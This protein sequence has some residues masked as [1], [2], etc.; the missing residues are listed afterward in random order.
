MQEKTC[1]GNV[2]HVEFGAI[3]PLVGAI[4]EGELVKGLRTHQ[5]S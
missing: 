2:V 5:A 4:V 3:L 1:P